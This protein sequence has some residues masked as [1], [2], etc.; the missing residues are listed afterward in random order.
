MESLYKH[1]TELHCHTVESSLKCG[2]LPAEVIAEKYI[3]AGYSTLVITD[4]YGGSHI[5]GKGAEYD[6]DVFLRGYN[7]AKKLEDKINIILGMEVNLYGGKNDYL[8]YGI[9]EEIIYKE[10]EM[11]KFNLMELRDFAHENGLLLYQA[12]PFR[13]G[14]TVVPPDICDGIEV[15]NSHPKHDSRNNIALEWAKMYNKNMISGSDAHHPEAM[16]LSGIKT[17]SEI[18]NSENLLEVLRSCDYE[19]ITF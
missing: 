14:M 3:D 16:A 13:N 5:S 17:K 2:K 4:H 7:A 8:L 19:L 12:H 11:Y 10:P 6:I 9:T 18:K 1:K 15:F